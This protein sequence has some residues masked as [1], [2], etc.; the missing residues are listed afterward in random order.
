LTEV[1]TYDDEQ[2]YEIY[3]RHV[4]RRY[5]LLCIRR[6]LRL[7][8]RER[9]DGDRDRARAW[10]KTRLI[11]YSNSPLIR[12]LKREHKHLIPHPSTWFNQGRY[13]D[14]NTEWGYASDQDAARRRRFEWLL[15]QVTTVVECMWTLPQKQ[16]YVRN[17]M[18]DA[19]LEGD[20]SEPRIQ[21][22]LEKIGLSDEHSRTRNVEPNGTGRPSD[23]D[24]NLFVGPGGTDLESHP[25]A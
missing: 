24:G 25:V 4:A 23:M 22:Q 16:N 10:L 9:F 13:D 20:E 15:G 18:A 8:A 19:F 17:L 1:P 14:E 5:A 7:L 6:C 21:E 12:R 2:L 3:P 11:E